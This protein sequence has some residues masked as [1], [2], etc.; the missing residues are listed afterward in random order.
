MKHILIL[1]AALALLPSC[2]S[3]FAGADQLDIGIARSAEQQQAHAAEV[4]RNMAVMRGSRAGMRL[5]PL[6][7]LQPLYYY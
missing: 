5:A 4:S 7:P 3:P 2:S 1:A 6:T